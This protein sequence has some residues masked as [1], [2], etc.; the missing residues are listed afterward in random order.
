MTIILFIVLCYLYHS[1]SLSEGK[2]PTSDTGRNENQ[3]LVNLSAIDVDAMKNNLAV[4]FIPM[5]EFKDVNGTVR[6]TETVIHCMGAVFTRKWILS[7]TGCFNYESKYGYLSSNRATVLVGDFLSANPRLRKIK[8]VYY[9]RDYPEVCLVSLLRPLSPKLVTFYP[10]LSRKAVVGEPLFIPAF[11]S[12][13]R[14]DYFPRKRLP[15]LYS[16]AQRHP[17]S[18]QSLRT[19]YS[20]CLGI[21]QYIVLSSAVIE[22][23]EE[24]DVCVFLTDGPV[25]F[26][27]RFGKVNLVGISE[28]NP[29]GNCGT[30]FYYSSSYYSFNAFKPTI[31]QFV[32]HAMTTNV[33]KVILI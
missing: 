20:A 28:A 9:V 23:T 7:H 33:K 22:V 12:S 32:F 30:D 31:Y 26:L 19:N 1:I 11:N 2:L 8:D 15:L 29:V 5:V 24:S 6:R 4:F 13:M 27:N 16:M 18:C 3:A 25:Y 10:I 21:P 14:F 17:S